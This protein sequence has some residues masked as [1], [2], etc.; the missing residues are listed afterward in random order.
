[1]KTNTSTLTRNLTVIAAFSAISYILAFFEVPAPLAP[2]FAMMDFSNVPA[3]IVSFALG[4]AAGAAVELIKNLLQLFTTNTAG[5]G[6]LANFLMGCAFVVPAGMIYQKNKTRK[7]AL[8]GCITG[9]VVSGAAAVVLNYWVLLPLYSNFMPIEQILAM[10]AEILPV[11]NTKFRACLWA[12]PGN[13]FQCTL[14]SLVTMLIYKR[15]SPILHGNASVRVSEQ[16]N[17]A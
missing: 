3:L 7:T 10:Y 5:I 11:I 4:P 8:I 14:Y 12:F 6:E 2:S 13:V 16:R 17:E 9:A 15:L 1:M